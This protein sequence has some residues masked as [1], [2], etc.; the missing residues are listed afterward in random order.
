MKNN[1]LKVKIKESQIK[2]L[3]LKVNENLEK[4]FIK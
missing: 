2:I 1:S 3:K 4:K